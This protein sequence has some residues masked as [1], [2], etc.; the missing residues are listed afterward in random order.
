A[1]RTTGDAVELPRIVHWTK[2]RERRGAAMAKFVEIGFADDDRA[3][4]VQAFYE[5]RVRVWNPVL[6]NFRAAG[7]AHA[8]GVEHVFDR[9]RHAVQ[10]AA[11]IAAADFFIRFFRF[12]ARLLGEHGDESVELSFEPL[13]LGQ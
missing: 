8:L 13:Q 7:G 12:S 5:S 4:G 11:I 3:G 6:Q 10:R 1:A 2:V 9:Y